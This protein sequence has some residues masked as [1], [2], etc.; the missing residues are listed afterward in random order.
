MARLTDRIRIVFVLFFQRYF[1]CSVYN[2]ISL[3]HLHHFRRSFL[4][5]LSFTL[6]GSFVPSLLLKAHVSSSI[7][8]TRALQYCFARSNFLAHFQFS[9]LGEKHFHS[10]AKCIF[11]SSAIFYF[12][13]ILNLDQH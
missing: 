7:L 10:S 4:L 1:C 2:S 12:W 3:F 8:F 6:V 11:H 9:L 5:F 13:T